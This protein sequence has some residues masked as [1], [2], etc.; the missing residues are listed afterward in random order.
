MDENNIRDMFDLVEKLGFNYIINS[1]SL[2]GDYD[3][4]SA[5]SICELV[6]P[7]NVPY[8]SVV[9]YHWNGKVRKLLQFPEEDTGD[10]TEYS[11]LIAEAGR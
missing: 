10:V 2:W 11:E 7:L 9:R 6:R 8:V 4:V 3:T 1:Q 5:L